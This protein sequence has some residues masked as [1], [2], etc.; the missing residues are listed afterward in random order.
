MKLFKSVNLF[1]DNNEEMT[2][3]GFV[4]DKFDCQ[5]DVEDL[6]EICENILYAIRNDSKSI[7]SDIKPRI[8][9]EHD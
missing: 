9:K 6:R 5:Q 3:E 1:F 8:I 4:R 7:I 2:L